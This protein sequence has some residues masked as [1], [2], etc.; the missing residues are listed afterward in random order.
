LTA[1]RIMNERIRISNRRKIGLMFDSMI[2]YKLN[3][4]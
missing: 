3:A 2:R 4:I 1:E